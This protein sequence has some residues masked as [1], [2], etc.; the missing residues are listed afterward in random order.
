MNPSHLLIIALVFYQLYL[1]RRYLCYTYHVTQVKCCLFFISGKSQRQIVL[2]FL[3]PENNEP[4]RL[5]IPKVTR[6]ATLGT[7]RYVIVPVYLFRPFFFS[8]WSWSTLLAEFSLVAE[9]KNRNVFRLRVCPQHD[10]G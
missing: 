6:D 7:L 10:T 2:W 3:V 5:L 8:S 9:V 1:V 4:Q